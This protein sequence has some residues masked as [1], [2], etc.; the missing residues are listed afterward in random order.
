MT[1]LLLSKITSNIKPINATKNM[2]RKNRR[3]STAQHCRDHS[4]CRSIVYISIMQVN[5]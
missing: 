1:S 4:Y 5:M 2:T 3:K